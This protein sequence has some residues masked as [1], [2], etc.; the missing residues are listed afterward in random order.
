MITRANRAIKQANAARIERNM[1]RPFERRYVLN[2]GTSAEAASNTAVSIAAAP[3]KG[4]K[5]VT[6]L[7]EEKEAITMVA[8]RLNIRAGEGILG[9]AERTNRRENS[10]VLFS[11]RNFSRM[12]SEDGERMLAIR[13]GTT[14]L[15]FEVLDTEAAITAITKGITYCCTHIFRHMRVERHEM[16]QQRPA[17]IRNGQQ[18]WREKGQG[19]NI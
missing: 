1:R 12:V 18:A 4:G 15:K 9:K 7:V 5:P 13:G 19:R 17:Y 16:Q 14:P 6:A 2:R 3:G 8:H 11:S 10:G